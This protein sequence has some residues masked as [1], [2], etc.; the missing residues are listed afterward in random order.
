MLRRNMTEAAPNHRSTSEVLLS[1]V[2]D[3]PSERISIQDIIDGLGERS[4]GFVLLMFGLLSAVA[5]PGVAT[6]TA[7]P[8]MFF[9]LQML[10]GYPTPWLPAFI[11]KR[12]IARSDL[13]KTLQRGKPLMRRVERFCRPRLLF[14][15]GPLGERMLG[16]LVFILAVVIAL[17]GPLTNAPPGIAIAFMSIAI[18]E[19][20]GLLVFAGVLGSAVAL[21]LGWLGLELFVI[22]VLPGLWNMV[23]D[24]WQSLAV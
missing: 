24:M 12:T 4:F 15:I 22:H 21:Y 7:L 8:L 5:P 14:L 23:Q 6:F 9:G 20:D 13:E 19:R 18:I 17:P 1:L 3:F 16:L 10:S 2:R 11:A